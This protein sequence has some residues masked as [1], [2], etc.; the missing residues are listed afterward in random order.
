MIV[1]RNQ[2]TA[3]GFQRRDWYERISALILLAVLCC[4]LVACGSASFEE[5]ASDLDL[6]QVPDEWR[7]AATLTNGPGGD[8]ECVPNLDSATCPQLTRYYVASGLPEDVYGQGEQMLI[9]AAFAIE[10]FPRGPC[11]LP[12]GVATCATYAAAGNQRVL[13]QV[14]PSDYDLTHV[15]IADP[16]GPIVSISIWREEEES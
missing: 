3:G 7:L 14:F 9:D 4:A 16:D 2:R 10:P 8:I 13:L 1:R 12:G 11:D 15:Q 6:L 5:L